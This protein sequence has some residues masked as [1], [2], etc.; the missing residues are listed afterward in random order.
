MCYMFWFIRTILG[1]L[2]YLYYYTS[3]IKVPDDGSDE[4]IQVAHCFIA[5]KC[6][7]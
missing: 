1:H 5:L 2:Y 4:P 3:V 6:C 7:V